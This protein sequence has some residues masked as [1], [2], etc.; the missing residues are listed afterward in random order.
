MWDGRF[1]GPQCAKQSQFATARFLRYG[2][3]P[4]VGMT[5]RN[6]RRPPVGMTGRNGRRPPVGM[7]GRKAREPPAPNKPNLACSVPEATEAASGKNALRRHYERVKQTQFGL[8]LARAWPAGCAKQSQ[9]RLWSARVCRKG[10]R[11]ERLTASLR[12]RQTKPIAAARQPGV[13]D[14]KNVS[15]CT[16]MT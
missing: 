16:T 1:P 5:G 9:S 14:E 12:A 10:I 13:A 6:G 3:R 4:P 8:A 2:R 11:K 7:T 15:L